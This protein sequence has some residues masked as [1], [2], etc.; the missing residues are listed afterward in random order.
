[1]TLKPCTGAPAIA[2][3]DSTAAKST[4]SVVRA[5]QRH[6]R[7]DWPSIPLATLGSGDGRAAVQACARHS[8]R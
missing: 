8:V 3:W 5:R 6:R 4:G 7:R 1:M 2:A